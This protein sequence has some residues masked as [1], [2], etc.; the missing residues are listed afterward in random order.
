MKLLLVYLV[1]M[2]IGNVLA[3]ALGLL[4][5]KTVPSAS[6]PAF[7]FMYFLFL[8]V[9]WHIAVKITQPRANAAAA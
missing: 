2:I 8:G 1:L 7:L 3:Y 5:E 9:N 6:L 4:V